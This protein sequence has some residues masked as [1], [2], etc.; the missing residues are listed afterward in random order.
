MVHIVGRG[1]CRKDLDPEKGFFK[2]ILVKNIYKQIYKFIMA[3]KDI[4]L[5]KQQIP[6]YPGRLKAMYC[7]C[8]VLV[9]AV[10]LDKS[11]L[12]GTFNL[13]ETKFF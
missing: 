8:V 13:T 4:Y 12:Y 1:Q 6:E 2:N 10:L 7:D 11:I 9:L 5:S 3:N